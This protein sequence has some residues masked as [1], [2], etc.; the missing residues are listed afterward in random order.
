MER[1]ELI[2]RANSF[3]TNSGYHL[4]EQTDFIIVYQSKKRKINWAILMT[5]LCCLIIPGVFYYLFFCPRHQV[6]LSLKGDEN[7]EVFTIG[8]TQEASKDAEK[9]MKTISKNL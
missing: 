3:F 7:V 4:Q 2:S 5:L 8:N 6:T 1:Q 9:F